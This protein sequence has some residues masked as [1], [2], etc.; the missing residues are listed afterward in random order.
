MTDM[1]N[2]MMKH[3]SKARP[4]PTMRLV[5]TTLR[6]MMMHTTTTDY[7]HYNDDEDH[8][9]SCYCNY[10]DKENVHYNDYHNV[11]G[12]DYKSYDGG[13]VETTDNDMVIDS[14]DLVSLPAP[15][16]QSGREA[17]T[18]NEPEQ[19]PE[20]DL[21]GDHCIFVAIDSLPQ[22]SFGQVD[23]NS[24]Y[25]K[26]LVTVLPTMFQDAYHHPEPIQKEKWRSAINKE[27]KVI[28]WK[29]L[30]VKDK[31][32]DEKDHDK[33]K[34]KNQELDEVLLSNAH[35]R[36]GVGGCCLQCCVAPGTKA[37]GS[38][39]SILENLGRHYTSTFD[40]ARHS[41]CDQFLTGTRYLVLFYLEYCK[42]LNGALHS[43]LHMP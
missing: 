5:I 21:D 11:F 37:T 3:A 16:H 4:M 26:C 8:Y 35:N 28:K 43:I 19:V 24:A 18:K 23:F 41:T 13:E 38:T 42:T 32:H 22:I 1:T 20:G 6:M 27:L 7:A 15:D 14:N 31:T 33:V 30:F 2:M 9:G 12:Q 10:N 17:V 29:G 39:R 34:N 36:K 40:N 25:H